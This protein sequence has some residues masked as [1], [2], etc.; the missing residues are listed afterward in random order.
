ML[1]RDLGNAVEMAPKGTAK[2][3]VAVAKGR[4]KAGKAAA[5]AAKP[6]PPPL[7]EGAAAAVGGAASGGRLGQI[8]LPAGS[9]PVQSPV[10]CSCNASN[11]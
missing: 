5:P 6:P 11:H 4:G 8:H 10:I 7:P 3:S 9:T 1:G 2:A